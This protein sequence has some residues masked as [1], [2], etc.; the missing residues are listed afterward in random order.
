VEL[1]KPDIC[2]IGA[3]AGGLDVAAAAALAG[4]SVVLVEKDRMGGARLHGAVPSKAFLAAARHAH[5]FT[6]TSAFGINAP[7]PQI[8]FGKLGEHVSGA[9]GALTADS[10]RERFG[11]LGVRVLDGFPQFKS[12]SR[13]VVSDTIEVR[14]RRYVIATGSVPAPP[15]IPGLGEAPYLTGETIFSLARF[16]EHLIVIGAG[17]RGLE[18]AQAF[19]RLGAAVTV[20]DSAAPLAREDPECVRIVL[21]QFAREGIAVRTGVAIVRVVTAQDEVQVVLDGA[22]GEETL[23]ASHLLIADARRPNVD[24][25]GLDQARVACTPQGIVVNALLRT[26]NRRVYAIGEVTGAPPFVQVARYHA[27]VVVRQV[28]LRQPAWSNEKLV[29][30]ATLTDPELAHVGLTDVQAARRLFGYSVLRW[31]Y[32]EN[33]RA[34]VERAG[35]GHIKV[36]TDWKGKILGATIVGAGASELIAVWS[37]AIGQGLNIRAMS[38]IMMPYPTFGEIGKSAAAT[39]FTLGLTRFGLR[40]IIG[41]LRR[42]R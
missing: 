6:Q 5:R 31:P 26:R 23:A 19:R 13:L 18:F 34:Q 33:D 7:P 24:G 8:D 2:I 4:K 38:G 15:D 14:A 17:P 21:D 41:V 11:G 25:L 30:R 16:P 3:G 1:L 36:I 32:H 28:L 29:P 12:R 40:R 20:L 37:L 10:T 39:Y 22:D 42:P 35:R 9:V 27:S